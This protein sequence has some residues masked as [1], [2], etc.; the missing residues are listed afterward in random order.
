MNKIDG[1]IDPRL[2]SQMYSSQQEASSIRYQLETNDALE[3]LRSELLGLS[4]DEDKQKYVRDPNKIPLMN[5]KGTNSILTTLKSR[6]NKMF[7]LSNH[8]QHDIDQRCKR[9]I[10]NLSI[11]LA[12]HRKDF[13]INSFAR[14]HS[15]IDLADDIFRATILKSHRG[16]EGDGI[17]K[18]QSIVE[19]RQTVTQEDKTKK[20]FQISIRR[21]G[22]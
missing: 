21:P 10:D 20:P 12:R 18:Q 7:S 19:Q 16:W 15:V 1:E 2:Y 14:L 5:E 22:S 4:W 13:D 11:E 8:E 9:Y 6:S 3:E 17:R